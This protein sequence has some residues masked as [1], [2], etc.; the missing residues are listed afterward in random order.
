M[1]N[2]VF[3]YKTI[4]GKSQVYKETINGRKIFYCYY[5]KE[6]IEADSVHGL[7]LKLKAMGVIIH[8]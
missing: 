3:K 2:F 8:N 7:Y 4:K 1:F 5:D 6:K